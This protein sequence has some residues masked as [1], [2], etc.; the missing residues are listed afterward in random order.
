V[1]EGVFEHATMAGKWAND[2]RTC[3]N[4]NVEREHARRHEGSELPL[5]ALTFRRRPPRANYAAEPGCSDLLGPRRPPTPISPEQRAT[6]RKKHVNTMVQASSGRIYAGVHAI[7]S[8][9]VSMGA[10]RD[11]IMLARNAQAQEALVRNR[12]EEFAATIAAA[13]VPLSKLV[14][15]VRLSENGVFTVWEAT[16]Q[17][18]L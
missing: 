4:P 3:D 7:T 10:S 9:G 15:E 1:I 14:L 13:G 5:R 18:Q 16:A 8:A 12:A 2:E 11:A 6:L 17:V